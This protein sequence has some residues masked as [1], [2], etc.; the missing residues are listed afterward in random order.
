MLQYR[1]AVSFCL[2]QVEL[3]I[4]LEL[5]DGRSYPLTNN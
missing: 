2:D 4:S 3:V 5:P 1:L